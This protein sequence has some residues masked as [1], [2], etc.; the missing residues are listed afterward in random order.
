MKTPRPL[1]ISINCCATIVLACSLAHFSPRS[2]GLEPPASER[3]KP[4]CA[5]EAASLTAEPCCARDS[6]EAKVDACCKAPEPAAAQNQLPEGKEL[7]SQLVVPDVTLIDQTGRA[8]RLPDLFKDNVVAVNF[9]FTTCT[10][11]CP[12][13]TANFAQVQKLMSSHAGKFNMISISVDP[14]RDTPQRL[15]NFSR[16]FGAAPGWSLLTGKKEDVE[17]ALKALG[18]FTSV[19]ENHSSLVLIGSSAKQQWTRVNGL[20]SPARLAEIISGMLVNDPGDHK[21]AAASQHANLALPAA[22]ALAEP[23]ANTAAQKY[24]SDVELINH[25]GSPMRFYSDLIKGKVVVISTFFAQCA[26]VCPILNRKIQ[27]IQEALTERVGNDLHIISLTVD[28]QN[29]TPEKLSAYAKLFNAQP[30][31]HF[32]SGPEQNLR[33]ALAKLGMNVSDREQHSNTIIIGNDNT[34]LWKK[35]FGLAKEDELIRIVESVL[36]DTGS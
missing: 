5:A 27:A 31:W 26:G 32:I 12:P 34:G 3:Q 11:I 9:I 21:H 35:A 30:G 25:E 10:T 18:G 13:M 19:K 23:Q 33:A 2:Y 16:Q 15:Q 36:H 24:F 1:L 14:A 20:A 28:P 22:S 6:A 7:S 8:V 17:R 4:C 29:D